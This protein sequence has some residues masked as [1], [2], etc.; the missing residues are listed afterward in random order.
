MIHA[1]VVPRL[2]GAA[3]PRKIDQ[4]G[5]VSLAASAR[6][7]PLAA[8]IA[9]LLLVA[10]T[11]GPNY[12]R[13]ALATTAGYG[14]AA[15]PALN[16]DEPTLV[17]GADVPGEWWQVY[18]CAE[19]D[20]LV[21]LALKHNATIDAARAALRAAQEQVRAQR[22]ADYPQVT[23]TLQPSRQKFAN[24]LASPPPSS[25]SA[26]RP[27]CSAPIAGRWNRCRLR[28]ISNASSWRRRG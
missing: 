28:P 19:L 2:S 23:G 27:T 6:L 21:A 13:P 8:L 20:Q 7:P 12:Q 18:H 22:G 25:A 1:S 5:G 14:S 16:G 17:A 15:T 26:I 9:P 3:N 4:P 24:T 11:V 10:C